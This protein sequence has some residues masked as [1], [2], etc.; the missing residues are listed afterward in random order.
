[1][2]TVQLFLESLAAKG[3]RLRP[4]GAYKS[5]SFVKHVVNLKDGNG[6]KVNYSLHNITF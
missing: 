1:M 5:K 4:E 2:L 3:P 6:N